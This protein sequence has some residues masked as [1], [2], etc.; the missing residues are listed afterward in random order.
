MPKP[1]VVVVF[2]M[3]ETLGSFGQLGIL[4]DVIEEY[5]NRKLTQDEFNKLID[6]HPEFI[7]P[8]ILE[9]LEYV[10]EQRG[11]KHCDAIMIYTNNQGPRAWAK[12]ISKYF[13]YRLNT[14]VFD[15]IVAAFMVNGQ[16]VEPSRTSHEKIYN[17]FI[18]CSRLPST[19]EVCFIDDAEHPRM[20]HD[21]VYYVK[22]KPYHYRLPI[23]F[24]LERI[25]PSDPDK[26]IEC[27]AQAKNKYHP[28]SL[29]GIEKTPEEQEVDKV[30]GTFML[31]HMY[32]FFSSHQRNPGRTRRKSSRKSKRHTRHL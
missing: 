16:R 20:I 14:H 26:Q 24:C 4:K 28:N 29:R 15:H 32:D 27:L 8:G 19:T 30:I 13:S 7:R 5:E 12:T 1:P 25:F 11:K 21:N 2:D 10:V 9:I 17:D 23:S 3:D 22:I 6:K 18:R 31:Q